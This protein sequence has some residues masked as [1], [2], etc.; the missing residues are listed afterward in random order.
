MKILFLDLETTPNLAHV[1]GLWN[2]NIAISQLVAP[3]DVICFG[4]RWYGSKQVIFK[5]IHH[6]GRK[7]MLDEMH[8]VMDE[9]DIIVGWN[10]QSFDVKHMHREF[11]QHGYTPPSPHKDLDLMRVVKQQ[12][13]M[14][15]NKLDYVAQLL[16]VGKKTPHT[17][18]QL[19]LDCM[20]GDEKAW[21]LMKKYQMQD[22]N[23]LVD[24]YEKLKPWIKTGPNIA[25]HLDLLIG[26][27]NCGST[28]LQSR[29]TITNGKGRYQRYRC[30]TCGTWN[31]GKRT[32]STEMST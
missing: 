27:R 14:P 15:S 26:C 32:M 2:Q 29:G 23:L 13:R 6:D 1:W 7:A 5:S 11:L 20:A 19:W 18:F 31:R 10:S 12:F 4:A 30:M 9:A 21:K 17:G 16:E 8:H 24:L 28:H 25:A 22:V 3:T